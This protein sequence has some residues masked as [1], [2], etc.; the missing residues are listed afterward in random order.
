MGDVMR[1]TRTRR[2]VP[3]ARALA[4][5][6]AAIRPAREAA[7]QARAARA[8]L[9]A[10]QCGTGSLRARGGHD[11]RATPTATLVGGC[12]TV[13]ASLVVPAAAVQPH[14]G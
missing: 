9:Q 2:A 6:E 7:D 5:P 11:P 3:S 14:S 13:P 12:I 4:R 10:L 1:P 8:T